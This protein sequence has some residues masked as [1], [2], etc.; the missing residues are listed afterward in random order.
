M[1]EPGDEI[2]NFTKECSI[3]FSESAKKNIFESII[4]L[5]DPNKKSLFSC[6]FVV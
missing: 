4:Y 6:L 5:L 2:K 3:L 1:E